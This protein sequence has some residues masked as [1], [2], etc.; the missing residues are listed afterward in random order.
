MH[1][2]L[3]P[4]PVVLFG[5]LK[6]ILTYF[7]MMEEYCC[8]NHPPSRRSLMGGSQYNGSYISWIMFGLL[9]AL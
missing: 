7:M 5:Y 3:H 2:Q 1:T 8:G 6:H 9:V 4:A